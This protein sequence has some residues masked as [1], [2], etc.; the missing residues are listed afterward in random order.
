[1]KALELLDTE[2]KWTRFTFARRA[3]GTPCESDDADAAKFCLLGAVNH[4]YRNG[5]ENAI[6]SGRLLAA[7]AADVG[8]FRSATEYN[9]HAA[10]TFADVRRILEAAGV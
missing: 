3:D 5:Q 7:I 2:S 8:Y 10:T 6:A 9:D 1:M 4:C